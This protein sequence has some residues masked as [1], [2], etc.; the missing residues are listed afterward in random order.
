MDK[1][2]R[3][4][5]EKKV[6]PAFKA[7]K[8]MIRLC[9]PK[10]EI[11]GAENLGDEPV[12][13]VSNHAQMNG[14]IACELYFPGKHYIWCAGQMMHLKEVPAYA[15]EDFWS[16]KPKWSRW[17]Y[18]LASYAI[19]PL[20]VL[21]FNNASTIG[22][23]RDNRMLSTFRAT[24]EKLTEGASV[25]IFPEC[26]RAYNNIIYDFQDGFISIARMY[27]RK[28]GKVLKFVPM[29]I[30]PKL[31]QMHIGKPIAFQPE[32]PY[33]E[34]KKRICKA[35]KDEITRI[36]RSLPLHTVIP[37]LN[38]S[39]QLYPCN[40]VNEVSKNEKTGG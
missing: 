33:E 11:A 21:V 18:K 29:Y 3:L 25:V 19:A 37:Y 31:K 17:F 9:Y 40:I 38:I 35:L 8:G 7:I 32:F 24:L 13:V 34:E 2:K 1:I 16:Y 6:S 26:N 39:K 14:P 28:T 10:M 4:M 12:I 22:V 36:G 23:Y 27:Y 20:S 5:N 30:A 15:Y